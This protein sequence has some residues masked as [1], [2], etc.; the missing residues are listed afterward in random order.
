M[1]RKLECIR[2]VSTSD[3]DKFH[4]KSGGS[5]NAIFACESP[6]PCCCFFLLYSFRIFD[7]ETPKTQ[8]FQIDN[9][10]EFACF[11]ELPH[12][13]FPSKYLLIFCFERNLPC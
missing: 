10:L 1:L 3:A 9:L 5:S 11:M 13:R 6:L 8:I 4:L 7:Q 12:T 2:T